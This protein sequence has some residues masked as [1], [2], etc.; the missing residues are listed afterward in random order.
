MPQH[1][2]TRD[3]IVLMCDAVAENGWKAFR[4]NQDQAEVLSEIMRGLS[5]VPP[6]ARGEA[7]RSPQSIQRKSYDLVTS[8][9]NYAG[10]RTKGGEITRQVLAEYELNPAMIRA[11]AAALRAVAG[12]RD[13]A[14]WPERGGA[15]AGL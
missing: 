11:E 9:S 15:R 4:A 13:Q 14:A 6:S 10:K 1:D 12:L 3:E 2:W 7:F 5:T 8:H